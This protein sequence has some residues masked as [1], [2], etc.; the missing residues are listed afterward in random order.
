M[1]SWRLEGVAESINI[2]LCPLEYVIVQHSRRESNKIAYFLDNLGYKYCVLDLDVSWPLS[3][4]EEGIESL[5]GLLEEDKKDPDGGV[6]LAT[7]ESLDGVPSFQ[8]SCL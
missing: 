5:Q 1:K 4:L 8:V 2:L 7:R 6:V 3:S